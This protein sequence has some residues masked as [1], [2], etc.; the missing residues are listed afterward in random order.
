MCAN[1]ALHRP[2][3]WS[4][5][6]ELSF[7]SRF[8]FVYSRDH[9]LWMIICL[10]V[11]K[12][13]FYDDFLVCVCFMASCEFFQKNLIA[14]IYVPICSNTS[15]A[16]SILTCLSQ[17]ITI[18]EFGATEN[19]NEADASKVWKINRTEFQTKELQFADLEVKWLCA[20]DECNIGNRIV[21]FNN[22]LSMW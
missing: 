21:Y 4:K 2:I 17:N 6:C 15:A 12:M 1:R 18:V 11:L 8:Y 14:I 22:W 5:N 7:W 10:S 19:F 16:R 13:T 9:P 3:T 20:S